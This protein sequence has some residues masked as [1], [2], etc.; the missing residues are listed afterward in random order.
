MTDF[1]VKIKKVG[2]TKGLIVEAVTM[3]TAVFIFI[4]T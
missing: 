3:D 1:M 4:K 2:Q